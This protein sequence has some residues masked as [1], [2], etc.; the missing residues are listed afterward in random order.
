MSGGEARFF[1]VVFGWDREQLCLNGV[2]LLGCSF[3]GPL[4]RESFCCGF[5]LLVE[6]PLGISGCQFLQHCLDMSQKE[7]P[8]I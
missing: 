4:V 7:N 8:G 1:S 6:V 3:L 5:L 2:F